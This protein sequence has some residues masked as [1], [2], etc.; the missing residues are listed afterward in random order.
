MLQCCSL[1]SI[2]VKGWII[3]VAEQFKGGICMWDDDCHEQCTHTVR[4][5][6]QSKSFKAV[7]L[8]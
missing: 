8:V 3:S 7:Q 5:V 2:Y 4:E 1:F 6:R